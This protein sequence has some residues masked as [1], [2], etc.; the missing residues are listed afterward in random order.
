MSNFKNKAPFGAVIAEIFYLHGGKAAAQIAIRTGR[1]ELAEKI[2]RGE[3]RAP[4]RGFG[5]Q[6]AMA[7]AEALKLLAAYAASR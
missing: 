7:R 1:L 4:C 5:P 3:F 6:R 2:V